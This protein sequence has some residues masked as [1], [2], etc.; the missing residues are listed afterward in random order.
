M[1]LPKV[2]A[3]TYELDLPSSGKKVKYRPF[4][5]KEEKILLVAMDSKDEKQITQA[6]V[7]V[8]KACIITRGIKVENLPSFDL[9][10]V[11][12]KIRAASVGED[13]TLNVTCL[14]DG[15]TKVSH[16]I[17]IN[18]ISVQKPKGHS[19]KI[20]LSKDV[21]LIMKYPS[22]NHFIDVGFV[23]KEVDGLSVVLNSID[24]IFEGEEVTEAKDCTTKELQTFIESL[25]QAQFKKISK[26]FET[27]PRLK[28]EF[29]VVNPQ[30]KK[31]NKYTLEGLQSFFV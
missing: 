14:D 2:T 5:V 1:S 19:D 3:P 24:Q 11:F 21:G 25:T 15:M 22:L 18:D 20:M 16:T 9:E 28:H 12:L 26:F 23:D 7:D 17:N 8:L 30:T 29:V 6:L 13:I 31:E 27:M 10:Y 4:I